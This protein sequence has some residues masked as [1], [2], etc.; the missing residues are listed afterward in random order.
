MNGSRLPVKTQTGGQAELS[1]DGSST[2]NN[3]RTSHHPI[4]T[5]I[6]RKQ[7]SKMDNAN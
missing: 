6:N 1:Q 5:S 2:A 4:N 7:D 3:L